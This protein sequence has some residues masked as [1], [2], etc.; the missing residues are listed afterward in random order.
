MCAQEL[1]AEGDDRCFNVDR[2]EDLTE[3]EKMLAPLPLIL[4][5]I[6]Y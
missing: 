5:M 4:S 3:A 2:P 1:L 6:I